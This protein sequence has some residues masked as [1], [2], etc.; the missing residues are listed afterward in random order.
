MNEM[1]RDAG[2]VLAHIEDSLRA[3]EFGSMKFKLFSFCD[4]VTLYAKV[5]QF[6]SDSL[7]EVVSTHFST[8][9]CVEEVEAGSAVAT[10]RYSVAIFYHDPDVSDEDDSS[11]SEDRLERQAQAHLESAALHRDDPMF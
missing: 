8:A 9:M 11:S 10:I 7:I 3:G 1:F 4:E 5:N 2:D 6:L